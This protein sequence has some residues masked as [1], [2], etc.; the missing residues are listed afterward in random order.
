[1]GVSVERKSLFEGVTAYH[2]LVLVIASCGW[3][4]DCMDQ[5]I[6]ILTREPAL[7]NLLARHGLPLDNV[8]SYGG[9]ATMWMM[10]GWGT[11]GIIF[12][13]MSDKWGRVK[14]M[15]VTLFL[16]SGFTGLSAF[17]TSWWDYMVY[18]FLVGLGVGGMFGAATALVAE[19]VP[20]HVRALA[21]GSLQTLSACGNIIGSQVCL[22]WKPG[23]MMTV[24]GSEIAGWRVVYCIGI[25]PAL[26]VVPIIMTLREPEPWRRAKEAAARGETQKQVG[27]LKDLF[28]DPRWRRN[29]IVGLILGVSGMIGLWGIGFYSPELVSTALKGL[30]QKAIDTSRAWGTTWQ[31]VG[32]LLGMFCATLLATYVGRRLAFLCSYILGLCATV[33]VFYSLRSAGDVNWMLFVLGFS[34]LTVFGCYSIYFPEIFPTRL[35]GTGIGFCY[36]VGR[37]ITAPGAFLMPYLVNWLRDMKVAEPFRAAAICMSVVY[38]VGMVALLW[39]RETKDQVL[40]ED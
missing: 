33:F 5:R 14:T 29:S 18:R 38:I 39:A 19:S 27:T 21:L 11:G 36:N 6:F 13:V 40:P 8:F 32:A 37:Y 3:L 22:H 20:S 2:W 30:P 1:M 26:L 25:I 7:K 28:R 34:T 4:F 31:D 35:R 15:V 17:A 16:Y 10:F 23:L 12:G 9:F 24:L